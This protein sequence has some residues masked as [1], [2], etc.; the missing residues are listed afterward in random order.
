MAL[1][2]DRGRRRPE[3]RWLHL[4]GVEHARRRHRHAYA[5]G[6]DYDSL[7]DVTLY[8]QWE[9]IAVSLEVLGDV[10]DPFDGTHGGADGERPSRRLELGRDRVLDPSD[11]RVRHGRGRDHGVAERHPPGRPGRRA[12]HRRD[13]GR[14]AGAPLTFTI[15][16]LVSAAGTIAGLTTDPAIAVGWTVLPTLGLPAEL[17]E[18]GAVVARTALLGAL[19]VATGGGLVML[20]RRLRAG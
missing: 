5:P 12:P 16:V 9:A 19:L 18:T 4:L 11:D 1:R 8:A 17:A 15:Y 20:R 13:R 10:G 14:D 2:D 7:A 6:D 3:P